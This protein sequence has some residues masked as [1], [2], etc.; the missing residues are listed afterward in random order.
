MLF[1]DV[2]ILD[3]RLFATRQALS[4]LTDKSKHAWGSECSVLWRSL[5]PPTPK[6]TLQLRRLLDFEKRVVAFD[7]IAF[8]LDQPLETLTN[9]RQSFQRALRIAGGAGDTL[10]QL[11]THLDD[12]IDASKWEEQGDPPPNTPHFVLVFKRLLEHFNTLLLVEGRALPTNLSAPLELLALMPTLECAQN[13]GEVP[14]AGF[15]PFQ[16][17]STI[18][19]D[20]APFDD[21]S[22]VNKVQQSLARTD[23]VFVERLPLL[24]SEMELL[25]EALFGHAHLIMEDNSEALDKCLHQLVCRMLEILIRFSENKAVVDAAAHLF[26]ALRNTTATPMEFPGG[27]LDSG[28]NSLELLAVAVVHLTSVY[29]STHEQASGASRAWIALSIACLKFYLPAT[30]FDPALESILKVTTHDRCQEEMGHNLKTLQLFMTRLTGEAST[31]RL[32]I[33]EADLDGLGERPDAP[34]V[35]RPQHSQIVQLHADFEL[36]KQVLEGIESTL[37]HPQGFFVES[38]VVINVQQLRSRL[39]QNHRPY[40]DLTAPAVYFI[41][42]L[43]TGI[44]LVR[45]A[46]AKQTFSSASTV[47]ANLTPFCAGRL[48]TWADDNTLLE[49]LAANGNQEQRLSWLSILAHR[50]SV[51]PLHDSASNLRFWVEEQ[52]GRFYEQWRRELNI[53]QKRHADKSSL[54]RYRGGEDAEE[55]TAEQLA[56]LFPTYDEDGEATLDSE[57]PWSRAQNIAVPIAAAHRNIFRRQELAAKNLLGSLGDLG[58]GPLPFPPIE[59]GPGLPTLLISVNELATNLKITEASSQRYNVYRD[60]NCGQVEKLRQVVQ[61]CRRQFRKLHQDWPEHATPVLVIQY[62]DRILTLSHAEPVMRFLPHVEKLHGAVNEWQKIA[63]REYS[64]SS[65]LDTI[66]DLIITWRRLELSAWASLF[67]HEDRRSLEDAASWWFVAYETIIAATPSSHPTAEIFETHVVELLGGLQSFLE[68][69]GLGEYHSRL[70]MLRSFESQMAV[71][72]VHHGHVNKVRQGIAN[73]IAYFA[74]FEPS[75]SKTL[76][77]GRASLQKEMMSIIQVASWKDRNIDTLRQSAKSS[78]KRLLRM[79]RKYRNL[80]AQPVNSTMQSGIPALELSIIPAHRSLNSDNANKLSAAVPIDVASW[81]DRPARYCNIGTTLR[82]MHSKVGL[83]DVA[84]SESQRLATFMLDLNQSMTE[85]RKATPS[86][87]REENQALANHLKSRKRRLLADVLKELRTMGLQHNLAEDLTHSQASLAHVLAKLRCPIAENEGSPIGAAE[88]HLH[89]LLG[90]IPRA[91]EAAR[92]HS[93]DLTNGEIARCTALLESVLDVAVRQ[94]NT[95][96]R[97][98]EE[99]QSLHY[100]V[101][102]IRAFAASEAATVRGGLEDTSHPSEMQCCVV[103]I[104]TCIQL[105]SIQ[106]QLT[107]RDYTVVTSQFSDLASECGRIVAALES[108]PTLPDGIVGSA[109]MI[110][111]KLFAEKLIEIEFHKQSASRQHPEL[112]YLLQHLQYWAPTPRNFPPRPNQQVSTDSSAW[113]GRLLHCLDRILTVMQN[114]GDV[115]SRSD[116]GNAWLK[117][118]QQA[119]ETAWNSLHVDDVSKET[120]ELLS[121]LAEIRDHEQTLPAVAAI[122]QNVLPL[123]DAYCSA[124]ESVETAYCKLQCETLKL[125]QLLATAFATIAK[126]GF[127][128][129]PEKGEDAPGEAGEVE[130]GTGLGEGEGAEDVSKDVGADEDLSEL[131]QEAT[132][133]DRDGEMEDQKD[134]VDMADEDLEGDMGEA[135]AGSE[136]ENEDDREN[137]NDEDLDEETGEVNQ[138]DANAIDEKMWDDGKLEEQQD[139]EASSGKGTAE[140]DD[141][142]AAKDVAELDQKATQ[143]DAE[144]GEEDDEDQMSTAEGENVERPEIEAAD[145]HM[146]EQENLELPDDMDLEGEQNDADDLSDLEADLDDNMRDRDEEVGGRDEG[147]QEEVVEKPVSEAESED[148]NTAHEAGSEAEETMPEERDTEGLLQ[149]KDHDDDQ[150]GSP[151]EGAVA[152]EQGSGQE[153]STVDA[154]GGT[155]ATEN[156]VGAEKSEMEQQASGV[157]GDAEHGQNEEA[158]S[159]TDPS[160]PDEIRSQF[161]QLGDVLE[162]WYKQNRPIDAAKQTGESETGQQEDTDISTA[163]FEHLPNDEAAADTQALGAGSA[164][165]STTLNEDNSIPVNRDEATEDLPFQEDG[166]VEHEEAIDE[167]QNNNEPLDAR[168][169]FLQEQKA[170]AFVGAPTLDDGDIPMEDIPDIEEEIE[171]DDVKDVDAQMTNTRISDVEDAE[172]LSMAEARQRWSQHESRTRNLSLLLTEHLRLILQPTQATK[173]RGDFRTG[174]RLNIKKIIPYIASS[175]KRDKIWMRRSVPSKRA[176]QILLAIDDSKSMAES[177]G[178][179]ALAFDTLALVARSLTALEAGELGVLAFGRAVTVAHDFATPFTADA[180]P[181]VVRRFTFAQPR[182]DVRRL[183]AESLEL[184]R[185]A[186]LRATASSADLWQLQLI[187]SDGVC[188]DHPGIRQLVRQAHEERIMIV[189]IVVDAAAAAATSSRA[190]QTGGQSAQSILD[191]QTAEFA[192]DAAGEMQLKMVK[193]MDTFPFRYYLIV[194]DVQEL[195]AVLAGALRQWFAEVVETGP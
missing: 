120:S 176:Y 161:K 86:V 85:L 70:E 40:A 10:E 95:L 34:D 122:C 14:A 149:D 96:C 166:D 48:S 3:S 106:A 164:E 50:N 62:C 19:R 72:V 13:R 100:L 67:E 45:K 68:N 58:K 44:S 56:D 125:G 167:Q 111:Y 132:K 64:V 118:G 144:H 184:F 94:R 28:N 178:G 110:N 8:R 71:N 163:R 186:R 91:R 90:L 87:R 25:T 1:S 159:S 179:S 140:K 101:Q 27:R 182:T 191:L 35:C 41:D 107:K 177:D 84:E 63:S 128:S 88:Y 36:L 24:S 51:R 39:I 156:D 69:C 152:G 17:L 169:D 137:N 59:A 30:P 121:D 37:Q 53:D 112:E 116:D 150:I 160:A 195:P 16:L 126:E 158:T 33:L 138:D 146:Q 15:A 170:K 38:N 117:K 136:E 109:E 171:I 78:H 9:L 22:L 52:F 20:G 43:T 77:T 129:P 81:H 74:R 187:I 133:Q 185:A 123:I 23:E 192:R 153:D 92:K 26:T 193:Y 83:I 173:M 183:L 154:E 12:L 180:G 93:D 60:P 54:Y 75:V 189:F 141:L 99:G 194:R 139:K 119:I 143:D 104:K 21:T 2:E 61:K 148:G 47:L 127:C 172:A 66:T 174:K 103:M 108:Q 151:T 114:L 175:Y 190:G 124:V 6:S 155:S 145:P 7:R 57:T 97:F 49:T 131:A 65:L 79:V 55:D 4:L 162:Q 142:S 5:K 29:A 157:Q 42:C 18:Q 46:S 76:A 98:H 168:E 181:E 73:F 165:Q 80:L 32:R 31:L 105:I 147:F 130:S 188:E 115:S 134:A 89:R 135:D 11:A 82:I 102:R 113:V